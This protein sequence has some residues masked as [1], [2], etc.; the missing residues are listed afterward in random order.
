[1]TVSVNFL[2]HILTRDSSHCVSLE[3]NIVVL[4]SVLKSSYKE[5]VVSPPCL[6]EMF[7]TEKKNMLVVFATSETD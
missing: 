5:T 3:S 2:N 6:N 4:C 7:T 1:M